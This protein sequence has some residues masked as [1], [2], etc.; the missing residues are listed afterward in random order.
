MN[1]SIE[2]FDYKTTSFTE[3]AEDF[4]ALAIMTRCADDEAKYLIRL[5]LDDE[6]KVALKKLTAAELATVDTILDAL[7]PHLVPPFQRQEAQDVVENIK[8]GNRDLEQFSRFLAKSISLAYPDMSNRS[9][10]EMK[11]NKFIRALDGELR[12]RLETNTPATYQELVAR[13]LQQERNIQLY[14]TEK[15]AKINKQEV[16]R[17][18]TECKRFEQQESGIAQNPNPKKAACQL[19]RSSGHE[20]PTCRWSPIAIPMGSAQVQIDQP[21][22]NFVTREAKSSWPI[23]ATI[24][25]MPF[26]VTQRKIENLNLPSLKTLPAEAINCWKYQVSSSGATAPTKEFNPVTPESKNKTPIGKPYRSYG[27]ASEKFFF[28]SLEKETSFDVGQDQWQGGPVEDPS[29]P[30]KTDAPRDAL[31]LAGLKSREQVTE[32]LEDARKTAIQIPKIKTIEPDLDS[33]Q[34]LNKLSPVKNSETTPKND[35]NNLPMKNYLRNFAISMGPTVSLVAGDWRRRSTSNP[36]LGKLSTLTMNRPSTAIVRP[37]QFRGA[38]ET[39]IC[40]K[41]VI[42]IIMSKLSRIWIRTLNCP[43]K[44]ENNGKQKFEESQKFF[45][46]LPLHAESNYIKRFPP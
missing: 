39:D 20:A 35:L 4:R 34:V 23:S 46:I 27:S 38:T 33:L 1:Y 10:E 7:E 45:S 43:D 3:W 17:F 36:G 37:K 30:F 8:R 18:Q 11:I 21:K 24:G 13:A 6:G 41:S 5:Y 29:P 26:T 16:N 14:N 28:S 42:K 40:S 9:K 44:A 25:R 31:S 15:L 19:C 2:K 22:N 12:Q 32:R